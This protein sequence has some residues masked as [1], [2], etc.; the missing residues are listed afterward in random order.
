MKKWI[1]YSGYI[2]FVTLVFLYYLFPTKTVTTY[3]NYKLSDSLPDFHLT[4]DQMRPSFPPGLKFKSPVIYRRDKE[5]IKLDQVN[6]RPRYLT[7]FSQ[8]KSFVI[9][10]SLNTGHISGT[11][12]VILDT[13]LINVDLLVDQIEIN[14]IPAVNE[15]TPHSI[16]GDVSG[17]LVLANQPPYGSGKADLI[18]SNCT[19]DF[20][21]AF[22]GMSQLKMD[23]I[24]TKAEL[25][26]RLLKI[27]ALEVKGRELNGKASGTVTLRN[28]ILKSAANISGQ[29]TPTPALMKSLA[30]ILPIAAFA[31]D[32]SSSDGI[33]FKISGTIESPNFS[34]Q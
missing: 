30:D 23:T 31:G 2:V 29:V 17:K 6:I 4:V 25:A 32:S 1:A 18:L 9:N 24:T 19:V 15:M 16:S 34:L 27:E 10:G 12:E 14:G 21:P 22:F 5:F 3:V 8:T 13:S 11:A 7:L 26:D 33:P 28:P 20:K